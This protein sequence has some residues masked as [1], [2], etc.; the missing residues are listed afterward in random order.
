MEGAPVGNVFYTSDTHFN[1]DFVAQTRDFD[2]AEEHDEDLIERF[3]SVITKRDQLWIL[4]DVFMGSVTE[5]LKQVSR[6]N[7][8]KHLVLGNHDAAHPLHKKSHTKQRR[9]LEVFE[10]VHVHEQHVINGH[11]VL[12]SHFP[13]EGDHADREDRYT[14]WRLPDEGLPLL[15]GH[16]HDRWEKN[17][18]Q[19]NVGVDHNPTPVSVDAVGEWLANLG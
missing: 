12:L 5:G 3:N 18:R 7:G 13:F 16:V 9:F 2:T 6:L 1:H 14:Q 15:H 17:G 8:I 10:S 19:F 11:K 4:G